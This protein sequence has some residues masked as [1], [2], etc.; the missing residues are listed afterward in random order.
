MENSRAARDG[1]VTDILWEK[2]T[3]ILSGVLYFMSGFIL[4]GAGL[5]S[6]KIP[7]SIGLAAACTGFELL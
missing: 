1:D 2:G 4:S 6:V 5:L 7:L 3:K